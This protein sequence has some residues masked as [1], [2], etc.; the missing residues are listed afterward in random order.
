MAGSIRLDEDVRR[1]WKSAR[2]SP[3]WESPTAHK[4]PA[5]P[6]PA[7]HW[8]WEAVR[9]L[10]EKTMAITSPELVER[11]V[12]TL[13]ADPRYATDTATVRTLS[14]AFQML[15]PGERA[16]PHRHT[17]SA[18]RFVLEGAGAATY[19]DGKPCPMAERDLILTPA[20]TWHEHVHEGDTAVIWLDVLDVPLHGWLGTAAFQPGPV[21][22][23]PRTLPDAAFQAANIV[24]IVDR[25]DRSHSPVFRY[26][27][28][29]ARTAL[30]AAP[31]AADGSRR[32]R[33]A[34]PLTGGAAMALMDV[35][36]LQ[37][38]QRSTT[39]LRTNA[40]AVCC[41]VEGAGHS[42]VGDATVHWKRNDVFTLPQHNWVT[43]FAES[44]PARILITSDRDA[45]QR[46]GLLVEEFDGAGAIQ[47]NPV[48]A[49]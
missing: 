47:E 10:L 32:V 45:M 25:Y 17:M 39:P 49:V 3:L 1:A 34:N 43:H 16:R 20:W 41:V 13:V 40:N 36:L 30:E 48:R 44:A 12:M 37:I 7:L 46:L 38:E 8:S 42:K 31:V 19:V 2:L 35:T 28:A 22:E 14:A 27:Y 33:Y 18:L 26:P 9:P 4:P 6:D 23:A 11:R 15:L 24:P 5:P 29:A 21:N